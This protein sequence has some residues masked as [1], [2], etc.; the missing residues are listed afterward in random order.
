MVR[1]STAGTRLRSDARRR[2]RRL[3][4]DA[5]D[6]GIVRAIV[7]LAKTLGLTVTAEG[8]E[9]GGQLDLLREL[10]CEYGQGY[11][12]S[13]PLPPHEIEALI[14]DAACVAA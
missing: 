11:L 8:I 12:F 6:T 14:Q 3:G 7:A 4:A 13:R 2:L 9:T 10:D 1:R 5:D